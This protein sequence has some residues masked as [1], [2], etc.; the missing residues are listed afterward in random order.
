MSCTQMQLANREN[1]SLSAT[2]SDLYL[3][4]VLE[5]M[6]IKSDDDVEQKYSRGRVRHEAHS[7]PRMG[8][9]A[10]VPSYFV[11]RGGAYTKVC[12]AAHTEKKSTFKKPAVFDTRDPS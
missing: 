7:S 6:R 4:P 11:E 10:N 2:R 5:R 3:L 1:F 8:T 9:H 12:A